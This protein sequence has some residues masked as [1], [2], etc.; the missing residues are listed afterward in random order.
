MVM[1]GDD[2]NGR[3]GEYPNGIGGSMQTEKRPKI[4]QCKTKRKMTIT[5]QRFLYCTLNSVYKEK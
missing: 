4:Q 3:D 5:N 2:G 1:D